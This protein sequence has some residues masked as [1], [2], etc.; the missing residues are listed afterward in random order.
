MGMVRHRSGPSPVFAP[1][2]KNCRKLYCHGFSSAF[3]LPVTEPPSRSLAGNFSSTRVYPTHPFII[4]CVVVAGLNALGI[5]APCKYMQQLQWSTLLQQ[6]P[7]FALWQQWLRVAFLH[8]PAYFI[9]VLLHTIIA[10]TFVIF[11]PSFSWWHCRPWCGTKTS[12]IS[13]LQAAHISIFVF[14]LLH[15]KRTPYGACVQDMRK[16]CPS[17]G[18]AAAGV[19]SV[20]F[21]IEPLLSLMAIFRYYSWS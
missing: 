10:C 14:V 9:T 1:P 8:L 19:R 12:I 16:P 4:R 11:F 15:R 17:Q 3:L 20:G 2:W 18:H 5:P 21:G 13:I 7:W 6:W